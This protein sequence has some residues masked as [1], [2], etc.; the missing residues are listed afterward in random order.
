[1]QKLIKPGKSLYKVALV[2]KGEPDRFILLIKKIPHETVHELLL[3][4]T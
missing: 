2:N 1:L 3:V 4:T